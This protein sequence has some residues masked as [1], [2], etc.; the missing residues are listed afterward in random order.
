MPDVPRLGSAMP[1][2]GRG[3]ELAALTAAWRRARGSRPGLALVSGDAGVGKTRL[4]EELAAHARADGGLVLVGRC[5]EAG[6][7]GL[8]YLPFVEAL[9]GL[10]E[11]A[12]LR[13]L[14]ARPALARML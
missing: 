10:S 2:V 8:P 12:D 4:L 9:H 3:E 1:L 7:S 5:L 14:R 11:P 13:A 6:E